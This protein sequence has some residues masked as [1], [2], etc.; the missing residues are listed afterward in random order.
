MYRRE[1]IDS[2]HSA[3]LNT[4]LLQKDLM[5]FVEYEKFQLAFHFLRILED[6]EREEP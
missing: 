6:L 2:A 4:D 5:I 1:V 3:V